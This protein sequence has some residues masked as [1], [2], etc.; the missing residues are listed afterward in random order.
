M[1]K[2]KGVIAGVAL[3][4]LTVMMS[5]AGSAADK[6]RARDLGIP[7]IGEP[8]PNNAITDVAGV[9]VGYSTI[10]E[11]S[12]KIEVGKGPIRTGV[13]AIL[14]RGQTFGPVFAGWY[15]L[16]GNGEMTGR[17]GLRRAG[18]WKGPS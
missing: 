4:T 2:A 14:P 10:I 15:S 13:T 16:N 12:G 17:P 6:P 11:G 9:E 7:F 1:L 8:G 5:G 18:S 3:G